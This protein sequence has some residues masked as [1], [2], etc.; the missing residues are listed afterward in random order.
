MYKIYSTSIIQNFKVSIKSCNLCITFIINTIQ[1]INTIVTILYKY[2]YSL[3]QR[4]MS[5]NKII[6]YKVQNKIYIY[7]LYMSIKELYKNKNKLILKVN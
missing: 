7:R 5:N 1:N 4:L 3:Y 6:F 2:I